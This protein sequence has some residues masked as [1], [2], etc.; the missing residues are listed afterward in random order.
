MSPGISLLLAFSII[1]GW[2]HIISLTVL[3]MLWTHKYRVG[4]LLFSASSFRGSVRT[5]ESKMTETGA[6]RLQA[7]LSTSRAGRSTEQREL[8]LPAIGGKGFFIVRVLCDRVT[9]SRG[10]GGRGLGK[11]RRRISVLK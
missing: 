1:L 10:E 4:G 6:V 3:P 5:A 7:G 9:S 2:F 8:R 11:Q